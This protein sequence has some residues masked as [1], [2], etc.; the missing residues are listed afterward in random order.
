MLP[1]RFF[2]QNTHNKEL[3]PM[4]VSGVADWVALWV[5]QGCGRW[6]KVEQGGTRLAPERVL[7]AAVEIICS[8]YAQQRAAPDGSKRRCRLGRSVGRTRLRKVAQGG[9][10]WNKVSS[11]ARFKCCRR[12]YLLRIRTTKSCTRWQ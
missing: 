8:E 9:T 5:V 6:R 3:H 12:D 1:S 11:G 2:A 4:A 7:N 10:R